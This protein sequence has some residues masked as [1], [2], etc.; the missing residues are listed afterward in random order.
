MRQ[1]FIIKL[2]N[3]RPLL[4][5]FIILITLLF[6]INKVSKIFLEVTKFEK[7]NNINFIEKVYGKDNAEEYAK[8][9]LEQTTTL[10]YK[11]FVEFT[12]HYR[13]GDF[14]S[15]SNFGNRCNQNYI[16]I[17]KEP[18]GG[19]EEI[20]V[21]GGSTVFG[22]GVKNDETITSYIEKITK[23]KFKVINFGSGFYYSTQERILFQ[24][25]L[26]EL[27][28]PHAAV[29]VDGYNDFLK[30]HNYNETAISEAIRYKINKTSKDDLIDYFK[31]RINRLNFVRLI[32]EKIFIEKGEKLSIFTPEG[33][34][35]NSNLLKNNQEINSSIGEH[36]N[37]KVL[38]ILQPV[39]IFHDSYDTSNIPDA[40]K[41]VDQDVDFINLKNAYEYFLNNS[42]HKYLNLS[43]LKINKPMFVD[44]VHYSKEF[45]MAIANE[46]VN[47]LDLISNE[48]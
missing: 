2:I 4:F 8:V 20:W 40:F 3:K 1:N 14:T 12:E 42:N 31:E 10:K 17:C 35:K 19:K 21:F 36:F 22:Y 5:S 46:I 47:Y 44:A 27:P 16:N 39:P 15:V 13:S 41:L 6:V 48:N 45:N 24:N 34:L 30:R 26:I 23:N 32:K 33:I 29:F 7:R 37:V 25:L 18:S 38:N 43:K 11:P 9:I 28:S